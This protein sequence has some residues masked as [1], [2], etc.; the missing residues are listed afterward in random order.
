[1]E[2]LILTPDADAKRRQLVKVCSFHL[3]M[4]YNAFSLPTLTRMS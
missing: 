2:D 1:M 3:F 4:L